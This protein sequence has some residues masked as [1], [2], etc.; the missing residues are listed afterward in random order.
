MQ[1]SNKI[2]ISNLEIIFIDDDGFAL[3]HILNKNRSDQEIAIPF[4][5]TNI[6]FNIGD[7]L[8]VELEFVGQKR[9]KFKK[10]IKKIEFE[11]KHFFAEVKLTS[12]GKFYLNQLEKGSQK[13]AKIQPIIID[14]IK[15]NVGD[16]VKA[17]SA[18]RKVLK[19]LK[20]KK[21][22]INKNKNSRKHDYQDYA[23]ILEVIGNVL[24]PN[25]YSTWQ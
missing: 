1:S 6:N 14:N 21:F 20:I 17:Q 2:Q 10:I 7:H 19:K 8:L 5:K 25:V 23:E 15:I 4:D 16:V 24:D 9:Y 22:K 12:K 18:S 3:G 11:K 13:R